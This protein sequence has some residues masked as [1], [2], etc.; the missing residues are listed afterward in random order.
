MRGHHFLLV[1]ILAGTAPGCIHMH[2]TRSGFLADYSQLEPISK[3]DRLQVKPVDPCAL[4]NV[5]SFYIE[6]VAW[7]ADDM[8]QPA[9]SDGATEAISNALHESLV[10]ELGGIRPIVDDVGPRTAIVRSAVTGVRESQPIV[11][12]ILITQ[13]VGPLFNGGAAAEIEVI[14]PQGA[15][16]AAQSV[17]YRGHDWDL[18]GFFVRRRHSESAMHRA[19]EQLA[20]D[21]KIAGEVQLDST[22]PASQPASLSHP[23]QE[24]FRLVR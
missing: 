18:V 6:P 13:I 14:D 15:Q 8:G 1:L 11:N 12:I 19:A 10:K 20:D 4:A 24:S 5:D 17:A 21:L 23:V 9:N 22:E 16:I 2:P 3:K 7:L